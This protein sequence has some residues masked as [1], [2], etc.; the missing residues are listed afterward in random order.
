MKIY[1]KYF[2]LF[3]IVV[4]LSNYAAKLFTNHHGEWLESILVGLIS[5]IIVAAV[6]G[7]MHK[8]TLRKVVSDNIN[9]DKFKI[10]H[11]NTITLLAYEDEL[12]NFLK[13][14]LKKKKW[15]LIQESENEEETVLKFRTP[16]NW[17]SWGEIVYIRL[18]TGWQSR[19][20]MEIT[21]IPIIS[22]TMIDYGKNKNNVDLISKIIKAN[23]SVDENEL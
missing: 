8:S 10:K 19:L 17:K 23:F 12:I 4:F 9:L 13:D 5:G 21:S 3:F 18:F 1:L 11:S 6:I 22:T 16:L 15:R 2:I 20:N 14:R 7:S